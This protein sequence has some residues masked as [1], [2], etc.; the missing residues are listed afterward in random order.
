VKTYL[1]AIRRIYAVS[2]VE[3]LAVITVR[4]PDRLRKEM[5]KVKSVNW[6][7]LLR[8]AIQARIEVERR[9]TARDWERVRGAGARADTIYKEMA[10]KYGYIDFNSAET[11]RYWREARSRDMSQTLQS[12]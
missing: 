4:V 12:R 2:E 5:R 1:L 6:S 10:S 7:A 9:A 3:L 11:I 8:D